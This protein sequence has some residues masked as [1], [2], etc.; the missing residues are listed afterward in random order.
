MG[1]KAIRRDWELAQIFLILGLL[2]L[3]FVWLFQSLILTPVTTG[4]SP[5]YKKPHPRPSDMGLHMDGV[6]AG[7]LD[8]PL[9]GESLFLPIEQLPERFLF[10][11]SKDKQKS[12]LEED[13]HNPP[14]LH[15]Q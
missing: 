13:S 2:T 4:H 3:V 10:S 7:G 6:R 1:K 5:G 15:S 11:P 12:F 14:G 8:R 9:S